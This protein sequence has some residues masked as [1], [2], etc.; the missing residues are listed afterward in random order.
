MWCPA[1]VSARYP[2]ERAPEA[3]KR[4]FRELQMT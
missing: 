1:S 3:R 4:E 2:W